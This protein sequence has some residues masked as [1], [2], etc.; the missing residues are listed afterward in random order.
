MH[1]LF[2]AANTRVLLATRN[3][4]LSQWSFLFKTSEKKGK[5]F[6]NLL[7]TYAN[8]LWGCNGATPLA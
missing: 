1:A 3:R 8:L 5:L 2:G 4:A 6:L 7:L